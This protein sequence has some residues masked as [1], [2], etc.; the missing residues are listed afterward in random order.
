VGQ[1]L[2]LG[3]PVADWLMGYKYLKFK[4][5]EVFAQ[6]ELTDEDLCY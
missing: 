3:F 4:I 2:S 6:S 5:N 1:L